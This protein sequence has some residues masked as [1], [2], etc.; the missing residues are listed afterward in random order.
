MQLRG[1]AL[2]VGDQGVRDVGAVH[3]AVGHDLRQRARLPEE[4]QECGFASPDH[5][6]EGFE[7]FE[8]GRSPRDHALV[9]EDDE[10]ESEK[11]DD[12]GEESEWVDS[13]DSQLS[14]DDYDEN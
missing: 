12:S 6:C 13:D 4:V 1:A 8:E 11:G 3:E 2:H 7:V 14:E 10:V 5:R 9:V